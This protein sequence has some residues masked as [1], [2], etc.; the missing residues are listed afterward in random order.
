MAKTIHIHLHGLA[1]ITKRTGDAGNFDESKHKR[2]D[3]G[4]FSSG[5]GGGGK[6]PTEG[7]SGAELASMRGKTRKEQAAINA[8]AAA[9]LAKPV[10]NAV[11]GQ[12]G[13]APS[14]REDQ[15]LQAKS[16]PIP[17]KPT[18]QSLTKH[19][20]YSKEDMDYLRG[21][22]YDPGEILAFWDRD[23]KAGKSPVGFN[24]N[25]KEN[26]QFMSGMRKA[27]FGTERSDPADYGFASM[28]IG[29]RHEFSK[30]AQSKTPH[31]VS[32]ASAFEMKRALAASLGPGAD[33]KAH[34]GGEAGPEQAVL[35]KNEGGRRVNVTRADFEKAMRQK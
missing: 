7:K 10:P 30:Q 24:K 25:S 15:V 27:M 35:T 29:Q 2:D 9:A 34:K 4:K 22:G 21:K 28:S 32:R 13:L 5:G 19:P 26:Q 3:D 18:Y 11:P 16:L 23:H 14:S 20:M 17:G 8:A 33:V 31:I 6:A 1:R 12:R